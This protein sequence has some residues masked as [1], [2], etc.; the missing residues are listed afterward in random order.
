MKNKL[1]RDENRKV[2]GGVCAGLADYFNMEDT[3][4]RLIFVFAVIF[5]GT[6]FWLYII[7]WIVIPPKFIINPGVDYTMPTPDGPVMPARSAST[8][9]VIVG[10][11]L[12]TF[13]A[14]FLLK[15]YNVWPDFHFHKL[16]PLAFVILGLAIIFGAGKRRVIPDQFENWHKAQNEPNEKKDTT[17]TI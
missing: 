17:E 7:L 2:I 9:T 15:E 14:L 1:Y 8:A 10:F 4:M 12:I 6:G 16:W 11:V 13:G 3:I 5:L